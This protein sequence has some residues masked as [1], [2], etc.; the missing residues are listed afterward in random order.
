MQELQLL[1]KSPFP[2]EAMHAT[3]AFAALPHPCII[4]NGNRRTE[5]TGYTGLG[6]N[7]ARGR[8][9]AQTLWA[10]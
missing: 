2:L 7:K 6:I 4:V 3:E 10:I 5:K 1:G 8:M 9:L